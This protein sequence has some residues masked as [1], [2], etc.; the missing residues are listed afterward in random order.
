MSH[1]DLKQQ[2]ENKIQALRGNGGYAWLHI[3][4]IQQAIIDL[5]QGKDVS[6]KLDK[7]LGA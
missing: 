5:D 7:L 3:Q 4:Q 6:Y 2:L 1:T